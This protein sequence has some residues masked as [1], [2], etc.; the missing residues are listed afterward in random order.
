M[1]SNITV[2]INQEYKSKISK[3]LLID[4]AKIARD[5]G[6]KNLCSDSIAIQVTNDKNLKKFNYLYLKENTVTDVLAFP[7]NEIW[8]EGKLL[9]DLT[10]DT[11]DNEYNHL[12]DIIV[13][14]P[15]A[16]KQSKLYQHS[17]EIEMATLV[18]HGAL[19]LLGFDHFEPNENI[20]MKEKT[21]MILKQFNFDNKTL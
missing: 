9:K 2:Q 13:S 7:Y 5:L 15:Q 17:I 12:G 21:L 10:K 6:S 16:Q 4:V 8:K 3:K 14:F 18:A 19:H 20:L 11:L 1:S